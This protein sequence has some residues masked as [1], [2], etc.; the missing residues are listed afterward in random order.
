MITR[1]FFESGLGRFG[2]DYLG[3]PWAFIVFVVTL[4]GVLA[5]LRSLLKLLK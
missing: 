1:F 2:F 4:I 3:P 5:L